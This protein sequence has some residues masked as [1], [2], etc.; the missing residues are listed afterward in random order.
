MFQKIR[1][2]RWEIYRDI[3]TFLIIEHER[4]KKDN[5]SR[6]FS[7]AIHDFGKPIPEVIDDLRVQ[8][9]IVFK[10]LRRAHGSKTDVAGK[11]IADEVIKMKG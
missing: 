7:A 10:E 3:T 11:F 2:E 4:L 5:A 8:F 1:A 9:E 6:H